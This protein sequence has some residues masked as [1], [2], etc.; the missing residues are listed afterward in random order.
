MNALWHLAGRRASLHDSDHCNNDSEPPNHQ[1]HRRG[2]IVI[3]IVFALALVAAFVCGLM[4]SASQIGTAFPTLSSLTE[5]AAWDRFFAGFGR[6]VAIFLAALLVVM[7]V[8]RRR[9]KAQ[10]K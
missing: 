1:A 10:K 8:R 7:V 2:F 3:V 9:R 4:K 6:L 5:V